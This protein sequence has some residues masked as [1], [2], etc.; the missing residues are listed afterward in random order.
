MLH[1]HRAGRGVGG[2]RFAERRRPLGHLGYAAGAGVKVFGK[3]VLSCVREHEAGDS[4]DDCKPGSRIATIAGSGPRSREAPKS[5]G[6]TDGG[7]KVGAAG[8]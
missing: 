5:A 2:C 8:L 3:D 7:H 4:S 6:R 1:G